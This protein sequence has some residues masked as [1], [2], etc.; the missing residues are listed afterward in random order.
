MIR[1]FLVGACAVVI[2]TSAQAMSPA[3]LPQQSRRK[4]PSA[5][6]PTGTAHAA[7]QVCWARSA[8]PRRLWSYCPTFP[9][10]SS[11]VFC[12]SIQ[13][14]DGAE[15]RQLAGHHRSTHRSIRGETRGNYASSRW[16]IML[17]Y[18]KLTKPLRPPDKEKISPCEPTG[19][20][21]VRG[22]RGR[23]GCMSGV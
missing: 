12:C 6:A 4:F 19:G 8:V 1:L 2:G 16:M 9:S 10:T 15:I 13:A 11:S 7:V 14:R 23:T 18:N 5:D 22:R 20:G 3:P 21:A 17:T